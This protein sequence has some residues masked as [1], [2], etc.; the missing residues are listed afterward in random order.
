MKDAGRSY[1]GTAVT[2]RGDPLEQAILD[3]IAD[4]NS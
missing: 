3:N 4:F 2:L 1:I